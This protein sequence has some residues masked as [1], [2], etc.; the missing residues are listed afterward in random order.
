[1]RWSSQPTKAILSLVLL[2]VLLG[3]SYG[4]G[5]SEHTQLCEDE[6]FDSKENFCAS[7]CNVEDK[8]PGCGI[9][10]LTDSD[11]R[12]TGGADYTCS[13]AGCNGCAG[14]SP[15]DTPT[16]SGTDTPS[17]TPSETQTSTATS[18]PTDTP[19]DSGTDTPSDT[20]SE[21]QTSTATG[22]AADG[23][24]AGA[25]C[26]GVTG[27]PGKCAVDGSYMG[28]GVSYKCD[29]FAPS[30]GEPMKGF[31][32]FGDSST[33]QCAEGR[34]Y[35]HTK[36]SQSTVDEATCCKEAPFCV[37]KDPAAPCSTK[38][39]ISECCEDSDCP[40]G[41]YCNGYGKCMDACDCWD[42]DSING[43]CPEALE[44]PDSGY[45]TGYG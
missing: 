30:C 26:T 28:S 3:G 36:A 39:C 27:K 37:T 8:W 18:S 7:W 12:N 24:A 23:A 42:S 34:V 9:H 31:E 25:E 38:G 32:P 17:D 2:L 44:C 10:T 20:P 45:G 6:K 13:C 41:G 15:T 14:S 11:G 33:Y 35:D 21:T 43:V 16:D 19:T 4:S 29:D 40:I 5:D 1:M 22:C